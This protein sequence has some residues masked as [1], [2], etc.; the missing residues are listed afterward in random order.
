MISIC[1]SSP[2]HRK[3]TGTKAVAQSLIPH[4]EFLPV[5][6]R[7]VPPPPAFNIQSL[8]GFRSGQAS[9]TRVPSTEA[10]RGS[11][12]MFAVPYCVKATSEQRPQAATPITPRSLELSC[13]AEV[14]GCASGTSYT[15]LYQQTK[16]LS[17][18]IIYP[19]RAGGWSESSDQPPR[20]CHFKA[21]CLRLPNSA[22]LVR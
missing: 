21:I 9:N 13:T 12:L 2:S 6:S 11:M 5:V 1:I 15:H 4:N 20:G 16:E 7:E 22:C 10:L 14:I 18:N 8:Y 19:G 17:V 3:S